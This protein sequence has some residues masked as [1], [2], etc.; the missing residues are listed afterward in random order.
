MGANAARPILTEE[1]KQSIGMIIVGTEGS[2]D[3][4]KPISTN[5][6]R[7]LGLPN[8]VRSYETKHACYSGVAA[9]DTAVNWIASGLNKGKKA[10]VIAADFSR[11]HLNKD[12]EF[13]LGGSAAAVLV[14]ETPAIVVFETM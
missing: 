12:H 9:L 6:Q 8:T 11:M 2:V 4:G 14:S 13:V 7:A 10:L 5:I 1:D 3:F